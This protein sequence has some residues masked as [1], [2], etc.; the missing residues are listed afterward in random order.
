MRRS[1]CRRNIKRGRRGRWERWA[2]CLFPFRQMIY[3]EPGQ[4]GGEALKSGKHLWSFP[5]CKTI[6]PTPTP[7]LWHTTT[8]W[9]E[10]GKY[11]KVSEENLKLH[12][13]SYHPD[14]LTYCYYFDV[15]FAKLLSLCTHIHTHMH[16]HHFWWNLNCLWNFFPLVSRYWSFSHVLLSIYLNTFKNYREPPKAFSNVVITIN[17]YHIKI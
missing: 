10:C 16:A 8:S 11:D 9:E 5:R 3:K 17:I 2:M 6:T 12:L 7:R 1:T 4:A 14:L 13:M 15:S